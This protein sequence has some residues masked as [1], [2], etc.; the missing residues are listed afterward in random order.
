M[1]RYN[2]HCFG[3]QATCV[4]RSREKP[5]RGCSRQTFTCRNCSVRY[6][7]CHPQIRTLTHTHMHPSTQKLRSRWFICP[8]TN[9]RNV[10]ISLAIDCCFRDRNDRST[11]DHEKWTELRKCLKK[12]ASVKDSLDEHALIQYFVKMNATL[13]LRLLRLSN[14]F[15]HASVDKQY[16]AQ[17]LFLSNPLFLEALCYHHRLPVRY[18]HNLLH[19]C[20][21]C[22]CCIC[23][24]C[25]GR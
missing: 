9:A 5:K 20:Y 6:S 24:C 16:L 8:N 21:T 3:N 15:S 23:V 4:R 2:R 7:S 19:E 11:S 13:L 12:R 10:N 25:C 18:T 22:C 1:R 17:H 14:S